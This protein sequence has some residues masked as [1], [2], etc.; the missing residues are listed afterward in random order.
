MQRDVWS[1][2]W[3]QLMDE[4]ERLESLVSR[5]TADSKRLAAVGRRLRMDWSRESTSIEPYSIEP[6]GNFP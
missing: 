5:S 3:Y 4:Q 1:M 2:G 6:E